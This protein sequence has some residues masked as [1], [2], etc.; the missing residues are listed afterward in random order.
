MLIL[1]CLSF[2]CKIRALLVGGLPTEDVSQS[3]E[4]CVAV[5]PAELFLGM[6]PG[7]CSPSLDHVAVSPALDIVRPLAHSA[8]GALDDV[9]CCEA[10]APFGIR[11]RYQVPAAPANAHGAEAATVKI[12]YK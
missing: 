1:G 5:D 6:Q 12:R 7:G 9:G 8:L 10:P 3:P 4:V 11:L 2:C